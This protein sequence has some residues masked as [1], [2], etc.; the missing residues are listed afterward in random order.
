MEK[1][2]NQRKSKI[3]VNEEI[4]EEPEKEE[5]DISRNNESKASGITDMNVKDVIIEGVK[6]VFNDEV[7]IA[8][9]DE[10]GKALAEVKKSFELDREK[11]R[12]REKKE[13]EK[14]KEDEIK[15]R[16][17]VK[18][19]KEEEVKKEVKKVLKEEVKNIIIQGIKEGVKQCICNDKYYHYETDVS[20]EIYC[21]PPDTKCPRNETFNRELVIT[22][23][24]ECVE[25]CPFEKQTK[26]YGKTCVELCPIMSVVVNDECFCQ[27]EWYMDENDEMICCNECPE[28]KPIIIDETKEC[29]STCINT[30][31]PVFYKNKCYKDCSKFQETD[32]INN[33]KSI[34]TLEDLEDAN[35]KYK[36]YYLSNLYGEYGENICYWK[37]PWYED[38]DEAVEGCDNNKD[39]LCTVF[40]NIYSYKYTVLPTKQCVKKCPKYFEHNFNDYCI[41]SCEE[42][43]ELLKNIGDNKANGLLIDDANGSPVCKCAKLWKYNNEDPSKL[44]CIEGET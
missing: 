25:Y 1:N 37:G 20:K 9:K 30:E 17:I 35:Y 19:E 4:K 11:E 23:T 31:C 24:S 42:G 40:D 32:R 39:N 27:D 5:K 16:T 34:E 36:G 26:K 43:N 41:S 14:E 6:E 15:R 12:E 38:K 22:D 8:I 28:N 2:E 21:L 44:E 3:V 7:K 29:V 18:K 33:I 10:V 13:R